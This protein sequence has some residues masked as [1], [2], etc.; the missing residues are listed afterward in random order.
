MNDQTT[1]CPRH[2][3][4]HGV[5]VDSMDNV[6]VTGFF[7]GTVD[8]DPGSGVDS[9][10]ASGN[11]DSFVVKLDPD[12]GITRAVDLGRRVGGRVGD[13]HAVLET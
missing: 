12:G 10:I 7:K 8:F 1:M 3:F 6:Y 11:E 2:G 5:C 9:H 13:R 4:A